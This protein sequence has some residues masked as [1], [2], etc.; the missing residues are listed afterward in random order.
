MSQNTKSDQLVF[1][2]QQRGFISKQDRQLFM[3]ASR[4]YLLT[5]PSIL[6]LQKA[7]RLVAPV[8]KTFKHQYIFMYITVLLCLFNRL[9]LA[10][11]IPNKLLTLSFF[12]VLI[13][14]IFLPDLLYTVML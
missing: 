4:L 8:M 9:Q 1:S 11:Y 7:S 2:G 13:E 14:T 5:T 3:Y 10:L 12:P 6:E